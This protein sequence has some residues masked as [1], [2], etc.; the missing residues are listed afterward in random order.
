MMDFNRMRWEGVDKEEGFVSH[1][2]IQKIYKYS[3][4]GRC[5]TRCRTLSVVKVLI[6]IVDV[7]GEPGM[8]FCSLQPLFFHIDPSRKDNSLPGS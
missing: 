4:K 2:L 5:S 3:R 7:M 6:P 1:S 8:C